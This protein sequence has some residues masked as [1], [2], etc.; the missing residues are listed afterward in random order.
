MQR[1]MQAG[2]ITT[3]LKVKVDFTLTRLRATN[4]V[5]CKYHI[6]DSAK[7]GYDIITTQSQVQSEE[8]EL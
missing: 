6:Y 5:M 2:N 8:K 4:V 3:N 1:H 7:S